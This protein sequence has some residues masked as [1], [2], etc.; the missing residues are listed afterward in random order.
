MPGDSNTYYPVAILKDTLTGAIIQTINL[1]QDA[2]FSQRYDGV[3]SG[4]PDPSGLG[5]F[6]DITIYVYTDAGHTTL[7]QNYMITQMNYRTFDFLAQSGM[8]WVGSTGG[9]ASIGTNYKR[10]EEMFEKL[11]EAK[12]LLHLADLKSGVKGLPTR[13]HIIA[14]AEGAKDE[15]MG[16]LGGGFEGMGM[17][18]D[19]HKEEM[20]ASHKAMSEGMAFL[21][22]KIITD[23][24]EGTKT[25][26]L[27]AQQL[28]DHVAKVVGDA[29]KQFGELQ[30]QHSKKLD[31]NHR[32][33]FED[34]GGKLSKMVGDKEIHFSLKSGDLEENKKPEKNDMQKDSRGGIETT[35]IMNLFKKKPR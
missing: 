14:A 8:G 12:L 4:V 25:G 35:D 23:V 26:N 21:L 22:E 19:G 28:R 11:I 34:F 2:L 3:F 20:L 6:F 13:E 9:A 15:L 30:A 5:R 31:D 29:Q 7:S 27:N 10:I 17:R 24:G 32:K 16:A 1:T 18:V 33:V